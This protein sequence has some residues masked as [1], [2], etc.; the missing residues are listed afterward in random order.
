MTIRPDDLGGRDFEPDPSIPADPLTG[1]DYPPDPRPVIP[2]HDEALR[3]ARRIDGDVV[4]AS[5]DN[6]RTLAR[7]LLAL[8]EQHRAAV[9]VLRKLYEEASS[10]WHD[11]DIY[12]DSSY[13]QHGGVIR[14]ETMARARAALSSEP[15]S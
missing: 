9:E 8:D 5:W 10:S 15:E 12:E 4:V 14:A 6:A 2:N 13:A 7:A 1:A 11:S 3:L